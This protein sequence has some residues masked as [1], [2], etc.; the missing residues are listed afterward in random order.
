MFDKLISAN[1]LKNAMS[2]NKDGLADTLREW[3]DAQPEVRAIPIEWL[4]DWKRWADSDGDVEL[5][6]AIYFLLDR[7]QKEQEAEDVSN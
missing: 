5:S 3:I 6:Q 7:W 4:E 2:G 1:R